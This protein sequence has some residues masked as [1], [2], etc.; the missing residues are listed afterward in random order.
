MEE[1]PLLSGQGRKEI[2]TGEEK[3]HT[4]EKSELTR[5][6]RREKEL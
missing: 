5:K 3:I 1:Q 2:E 4:Y 6:V